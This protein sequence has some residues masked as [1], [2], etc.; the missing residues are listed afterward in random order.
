VHEDGI[1]D[2]DV[3]E[4][5]RPAVA[6]DLCRGIDGVGRRRAAARL[7]G[8]R[9]RRL[10]ADSPRDMLLAREPTA[11]GSERGAAEAV[12]PGDPGAPVGRSRRRARMVSK[13]KADAPADDERCESRR[14]DLRHPRKTWGALPGLDRLGRRGLEL[15]VDRAQGIS[16]GSVGVLLQTR[17][18]ACESAQSRLCVSCEE[19]SR[20]A[21]DNANGVAPQLNGFDLSFID[22]LVVPA[23]VHDVRGRFLHMNA[24]AEQAS[25]RTNAEM[26][27]CHVTDLVP[28]EARDHVQ[29][30]FSH[31]VAHAAPAD[32]ETV[33]IDA[34][35]RLRGV[36]AQHL[37]LTSGDRVVGVLILAFEVCPPGPALLRCSGMPQLTARQREILEL[38]ASGLA[39]SEIASVLTIARDTVRNHLRN[40]LRELDAHTR[41]EAIARARRLGLLAPAPLGPSKPD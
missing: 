32:F 5:C 10:R 25:G 29:S 9:C 36:R 1:A 11:A 20:L 18:S 34:S 6:D 4:R 33:F 8:D 40:L 38:A 14:S 26:R 23:S 31:A 17:R 28:A 24:G 27:G 12:R 3:G 19:A 35:G 39:T 21:H 30:Q 16:F 37:P 15:V 2:L 22:G 7:H 13:R 41:S